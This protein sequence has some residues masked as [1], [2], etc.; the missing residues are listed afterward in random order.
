MING[1][2][3]ILD[4][5]D[6]RF[7][8]IDIFGI[9]LSSIST[10]EKVG[11]EV[12]EFSLPSGSALFL[13]LALKARRESLQFS[14]KSE[15]NIYPK[16]CW[17]DDHQNLF[18]FFESMIAQIIFS[19]SAIESFANISIPSDYLFNHRSK[20]GKRETFDTNKIEKLTNLDTKLSIILPEILKTANPKGKSVWESYKKLERLRNRVIHLKKIDISS[21]EWE[22]K[23]IWGDFVR[24]QNEDYSDYAYKMIG[25]FLVKKGGPRWYKK[26]PYHS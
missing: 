4:K 10:E 5:Q 14:I 26:F 20:E 13:S 18:N 6:P 3:D 19:Y 15:F 9:G 22:S 1:K 16:G 11:K 17:P 8:S 12:V 2:I 25:H 23:T 24:N 7:Y 21:S